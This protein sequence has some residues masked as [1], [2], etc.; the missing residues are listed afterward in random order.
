M[1]AFVVSKDHIDAIVT[2]ALFGVS[3]CSAQSGQWFPPYFG[4]PSR[5]VDIYSVNRLGEMLLLENEDSVR[6]RYPSHNDSE[7]PVYI[8]PFHSLPVPLINAVAALKLIDCY[9]YQSC[10]HEEWDLSA[11]KRFCH[12]LRSSLITSLPGYDAA[13]WAI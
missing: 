1:S 9:E 7:A 4:N 12:N 10:E 2:V 3:E 11:T 8:Y 6:A 13:P 5:P